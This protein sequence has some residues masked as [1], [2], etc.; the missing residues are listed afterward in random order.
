MTFPNPPTLPHDSLEEYERNRLKEYPSPGS[1]LDM[2]YWDQVNGTTTFKD[3]IQ[4]IKDRHP[5]P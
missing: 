1:L 5:K 3:F 4:A 2:I